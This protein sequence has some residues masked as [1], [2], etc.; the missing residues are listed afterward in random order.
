LLSSP[1]SLHWS[2][3]TAQQRKKKSDNSN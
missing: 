1:S 3:A 2:W